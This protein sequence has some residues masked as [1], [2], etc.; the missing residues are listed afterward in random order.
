MAG[1][2]MAYSY[3]PVTNSSFAKVLIIGKNVR[4][5]KRV[6]YVVMNDVRSEIWC[7][8]RG[9]T[10]E[11]TAIPPGPTFGKHRMLFAPEID[12]EKNV[13]GKKSHN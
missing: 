3:I 2:F 4:T 10:P 12:V 11:L 7:S 9:T 5:F 1:P 8:Q 6:G 13:S